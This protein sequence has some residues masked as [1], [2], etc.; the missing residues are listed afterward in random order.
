[1]SNKENS[2]NTL[3]VYDSVFWNTARVLKDYL[4]YLV[5]EAFGE[6]TLKMLKSL[7]RLIKRL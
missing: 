7:S 6:N 4:P 5:N 1:M 3:K 2:I